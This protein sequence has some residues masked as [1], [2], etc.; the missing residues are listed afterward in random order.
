M[1]SPRD[2]KSVYRWT[3]TL[4]LQSVLQILTQAMRQSQTRPQVWQPTPRW[5]DELTL[6]FTFCASLR[7]RGLGG[8]A[9]DF[10]SEPRGGILDSQRESQS[11]DITNGVRLTRRD[12]RANKGSPHHRL[13]PASAYNGLRPRDGLLGSRCLLACWAAALITA[14]GP[15]P[16][17]DWRTLLAKLYLTSPGSRP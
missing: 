5:A 2:A 14:C 10:S 13:G 15:C 16:W 7:S 11:S 12:G 8:A 6:C 4:R 17:R 9:A 1:Q 3:T